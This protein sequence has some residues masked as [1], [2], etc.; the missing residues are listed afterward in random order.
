MSGEAVYKTLLRCYPAA[1]RDEYGGQMLLAFAEELGEARRSGGWRKRVAL[2]AGAAVDALTIAPREHCHVIVQDLRYTLRTMAGEPGFTTVAILSLA[3]GIGANTA[4]F[5]LWN[6]M[7]HSSL[8]GVKQPEQLVMLSNPNTAGGWHGN[9][10]GVRDWLT[11]AEFEQLRDRAASFSGVMASQSSL[12]NWQVRF[13]GRDWE[14]AQGRLVSSGYF[15]VL[16]VTPLLGRT[17]AAADSPYA[18]ISYNYWRRRFGASPEVLGKTLRVGNASLAVIGVA[19]RGFIGETAGQQPDLWIPLGMQPAVMPGDDWLHDTP[20]EKAMWLHVFGRLKPGVTPAR[21]EAEANSIF[22]AGLQSFYGVVA[23]VQRRRELFDQSLKIQTGARGASRTRGDFA[24]SLTA[25]LAAVGLLLLIAC[26]NLANL[27]LARGAARRAE[28][29]VRLSLGASRGRLVRQLI[30]ESLV[31]AVFGGLGGLA[32][33]YFFHGVLV[34]MVAASHKDFRMS[35][36]LDP[37]MLAFTFAVTL[38]A[39]LLFGLLPAWQ[40]TKIDAGI[41]LKEQSRSATGSVAHMRWGRFLAALQ[42]ALCVPLLVAAGLLARTLYNM[43]HV[44]LGYPAARLLLL[45]IDARA[46]G[47]DSARG[48]ILFRKLLEEFRRIPGIGAASFSENGIFSGGHSSNSVEVE[49]HTPKG[50]RDRDAESDLVG[51]GYFSTLGV[52]IIGGREIL[53]GDS[54]AAP[55][56]CVINEA[57]ARQFFLKR[58]PIGMRVTSIDNLNRTTYQIVG[59]AGNARTQTLRQEVEPQFYI[60]AAQPQTDNLKRAVFLIRTAIGITPALAAVR[61]VVQ[62]V[63]PTLPMRSARSLD[64][65]MAPLTARDHAT[66]QLAVAF[67]SIALMLAAIG[68]YGVMSYGVAR[69]T[70]EIAI[71]IALGARAGRVITMIFR[72]TAGLVIAGLACGAG[73]AYA[74]SRAIA[75]QLYGIAPQDPFTLAAATGA[76][77]VVIIGAIYLPARRASKLNPIAA[78]RQE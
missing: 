56:V 38:A 54:R 2:W 74:A 48:D 67:G 45:R 27:L 46:A 72:E 3:L 69:R 71:R 11:Y 73:L 70:G 55:K 26:A 19:P 68:L 34:R 62:G 30:T 14:E 29:A 13:A 1:F 57:F 41:G 10:R 58:N 18:V 66:A 40:I 60:P 4:I 7:L 8:P 5:S 53:S 31:L 17:F 35:F 77:L 75:S 16:G 23:S 76:L 12:E 22:K 47:Y 21:A 32:A 43:Q 9:T 36:A 15:Q 49:G 25:L 50:D 24:T 65:Q 6:G 52:P 59:I 20:P 61:R 44:E 42:V 33:V 78:L 37:L 28:L 39:A 64:E 51:P 63:D